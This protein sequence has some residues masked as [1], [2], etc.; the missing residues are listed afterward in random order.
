MPAKGIRIVRD[1]ETRK[2]VILL[3][4]YKRLGG[5]LG[6]SNALRWRKIA[7]A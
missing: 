2:G 1:E 5:G 3:D 4:S 6:D 7:T